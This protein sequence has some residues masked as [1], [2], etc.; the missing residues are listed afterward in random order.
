VELP[1]GLELGGGDGLAEHAVVGRPEHHRDAAAEGDVVDHGGRDEGPG[2]ALAHLDLHGED[3][4]RAD[5]L[6]DAPL[7]LVVGARD[8]RLDAELLEDGDGEHARREVLADRH[9]RGVHV[10]RAHGAERLGLDAVDLR[11]DG[12]PVAHGV[13]ESHVG[14]HG[15][16]LAAR[17]REP[18]GDGAAE[19]PEPDHEKVL[20]AP[21]LP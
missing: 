15:H 6:E 21:L 10:G 17:L 12:D 20:H 1:A 7:P 3:A 11:G 8:D 18:L 5:E 9:D 13:H 19:A 14:V 16:D 4:R 2:D